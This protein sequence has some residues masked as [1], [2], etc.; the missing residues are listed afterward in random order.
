MQ[1]NKGWVVHDERDR[2]IVTVM[3]Q[4]SGRETELTEEWRGG[5]EL[6]SMGGCKEPKK[7]V[8]MIGETSEKRNHWGHIIKF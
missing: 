4:E 1:S 6:S 3:E 2:S 8:L 5:G 7:M